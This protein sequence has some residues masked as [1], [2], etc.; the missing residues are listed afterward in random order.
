MTNRDSSLEVGQIFSNYYVIRR[1]GEGGMGEVYEVFDTNLGR[2][3]ALKLL[4]PSVARD[5][6]VVAR[7]RREAKVASQLHHPGVVHIF[8][9]GELSELGGAPYFLMEYLEGETLSERIRR[10]GAQPGGR[11]GLSCLVLLEQIARVLTSVHG[12]GLVHRDLKPANVMIVADPHAPG[13]ERAKLLDFGIVKIL[14]DSQPLPET[15]MEGKTHS[16][17]LLGTPQYMA[18]ELWRELGT[19]DGKADVYALGVI[20]FLGL[21][22]RLPFQAADAPSLG[23]MHCYK[24]PPRLS[25]L[26]P[27]L[28]PAVCSLIAQMLEKDA[29]QRPKMAVVAETLAKLIAQYCDGTAK[30]AEQAGHAAPDVFDD[31]LSLHVLPGGAE[32]PGEIPATAELPTATEGS[33]LVGSRDGVKK[34]FLGGSFG[35][36]ARVFLLF[37]SVASTTTWLWPARH[38][39]GQPDVGVA[40]SLS[41]PA[42]LE[43]AKGVLSGT[44]AAGLVPG[45]APQPDQSGL[46]D[47]RSCHHLPPSVSWLRNHH[48]HSTQRQLVLQALSRSQVMLCPGDHLVFIG[49][50]KTP[51]LK[52][53]PKAV[54]ERMRA[55]LVRE[56]SALSAFPALPSRIEL[57]VSNHRSSHR[58]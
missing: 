36:A 35:A 53:A 8:E 20:A 4:A 39:R 12:H 11:L 7:F 31:S 22:G 50:P 49:V 33:L 28:P 41:A 17:M 37:F 15:S 45:S 40:M 5:R 52:V 30:P 44:L 26:D 58:F 51:K 6:A 16:G 29:A 21:S 56:L 24:A 42:G 2:R 1:I 14:K 43:S 19:I 10:V 57:R 46:H 48:L 23:M 9:Y 38:F 54:P 34:D 27:S 13:G 55:D 25:N 3:V 18:P 47:G 32:V